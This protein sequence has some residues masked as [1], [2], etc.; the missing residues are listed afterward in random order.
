MQVNYFYRLS[1]L[2]TIFRFTKKTFLAIGAL[3][4]I[5]LIYFLASIYVSTPDI[6]DKTSLNLKREKVDTN[7][8]KIKK[9][10]LKKSRSGLWELYLE[11]D[12]FERGVIN[13]KLTKELGE[14][15]EVA[16][17]NQIKIIIP[18]DFYLNFLK[19]FVFAYIIFST[20][21]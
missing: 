20:Y 2:K 16:F 11:G 12:G 6:K 13:G 18:S 3:L 21:A 5:F 1:I 9:N 17:V 8:Y 14:Q 4:V 15:Q 7:F 19:Y 10:W